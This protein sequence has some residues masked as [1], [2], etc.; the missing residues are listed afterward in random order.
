MTKK[1]RKTFKHF[2]NEKSFW[3]QI[4]S[5]YSLILKGFHWSKEGE[6]FWESE[7]PTLKVIKNTLPNKSG[8]VENLKK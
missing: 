5:N 4:K 8:N 1:S 3:D 6:N 2:E 7:S